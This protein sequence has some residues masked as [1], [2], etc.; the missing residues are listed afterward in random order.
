MAEERIIF[1]IK[2]TEAGGGGL[3]RRR[4]GG[5]DISNS[6]FHY[7]VAGV[8]GQIVEMGQLDSVI[9]LTGFSSETREYLIRLRRFLK[10]ERIASTD[11]S[12]RFTKSESIAF[13]CQR[14]FR[15][16]S[17]IRDYCVNS[18]FRKI[19]ETR[20]YCVN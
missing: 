10:P 7:C 11:S 18:P 19:S 3:L 8:P 15:K 9:F 20:E 4:R 1:K 5:A 17:E 13:S 12:G 6:S 14:P 2:W 16:I